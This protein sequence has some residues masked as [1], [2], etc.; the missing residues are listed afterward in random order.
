MADVLIHTNNNE[1][2]GVTAMY[3]QYKA[4]A[5]TVLDAYNSME[6]DAL[7][8]QELPLLF[9]DTKSLI[10]DKVTGGEV[11][12]SGV[13]LDKSKA[14]EIIA[15]PTG[16]DELLASIDQFGEKCIVGFTDPY[17]NASLRTRKEQVAQFVTIDGNGVLVYTAYTQNQIS[18]AGKYYAKSDRAKAEY[19]FAQ[20]VANKFFELGLDRYCGQEDKMG[21]HTTVGDAIES[22]NPEAQTMQLNYKRIAGL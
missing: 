12:I 14:I 6:L 17:G 9:T 10:F 1:V 8:A 21:L 5:Q 2:S 7:T 18:K 4:A 20:A 16:Y 19:E 22:I 15:K 13:K 3:Q 11:S